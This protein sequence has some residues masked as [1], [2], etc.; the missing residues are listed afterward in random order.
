MGVNDYF[1]PI[2]TEIPH[3]TQ[4]YGPGKSKYKV[5]YWRQ[6]YFIQKSSSYLKKK[7]GKSGQEVFVWMFQL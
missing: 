7:K 5:K 4:M 1:D 6:K 2:K 3:A